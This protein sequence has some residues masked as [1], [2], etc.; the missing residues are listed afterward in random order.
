MERPTVRAEWFRL[1]Q[2]MRNRETHTE[3]D[4]VHMKP[5]FYFAFAIAMDVTVKTAK[6]CK[7]QGDMEQFGHWLRTVRQEATDGTAAA[8]MVA[9][10]AQEADEARAPT[11]RAASWWDR[12]LKPTTS[13]MLC[14]VVLV[15]IAVTAGFVGA[16]LTR[17]I[18]PDFTTTETRLI[19]PDYDAPRHEGNDPTRDFSTPSQYYLHSMG[20]AQDDRGDRE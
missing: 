10:A 7:D 8:R 17:W 5:L 4:I 9:Q 14:A 20:K 16:A 15:L 1:Q 11:A 2:E 18:G 13:A 19:G 12:P 6:Y 3:S